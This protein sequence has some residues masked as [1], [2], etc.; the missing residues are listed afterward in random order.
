MKIDSFE[1]IYLHELK[2]LYSAE[3]QLLD[4]LP[5]MVDAARDSRLQKAFQSH[6]EQTRKHVERLE[7]IFA[8]L[9]MQPGGQKCEGMQG[10]I[11]EGSSVIEENTEPT[12]K[13]VML[14]AAAQRVEHYEI[15][16]YGTARALAESLGRKDDAR[17]LQKT[18]D[19]EAATDDKLTR[20][21]EERVNP[22]AKEESAEGSQTAK[23]R[24][25][26]GTEAPSRARPVAA[27]P[28]S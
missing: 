6:L 1:K 12:F 10:L 15:A 25:K 28:R 20:I 13:D 14:I 23:R 24:E 4:A 9:D 17:R 8:G 5:K 16:G 27:G 19:E 26:A 18:L 22:Q 3:N 7:K 2:D 21:A 11:E